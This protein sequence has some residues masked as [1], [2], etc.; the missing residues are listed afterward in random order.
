MPEHNH[1]GEPSRRHY[2]NGCRHPDCRAADQKYREDYRRGRTR[3]TAARVWRNLEPVAKAWNDEPNEEN[4][5]VLLK[6][7]RLAVNGFLGEERK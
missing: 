4:Q 6:Y 1:S 3:N 2:N 7:I 5:A